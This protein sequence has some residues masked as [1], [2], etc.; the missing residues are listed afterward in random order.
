M[1]TLT[2]TKQK[3][4]KKNKK[5]LSSSPLFYWRENTVSTYQWNNYRLS[6][7]IVISIITTIITITISIRSNM[8]IFNFVDDN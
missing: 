4:R 1:T 3:I 7:E 8:R 6:D 2:R 5:H